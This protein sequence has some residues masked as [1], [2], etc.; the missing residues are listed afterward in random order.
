MMCLNCASVI[1]KTTNKPF[2]QLGVRFIQLIQRCAQ[3]ECAGRNVR[4]R[5]LVAGT[6]TAFSQRSAVNAK[7]S[8]ISPRPGLNRTL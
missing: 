1:R 2:G 6:A 4:V 5:V 8:A 7:T 3:R